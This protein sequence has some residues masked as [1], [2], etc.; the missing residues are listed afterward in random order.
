MTSNVLSNRRRSTTL[1]FKM[2]L[3]SPSMQNFLMKLSS[4]AAEFFVGV[5]KA[6]NEAALPAISALF[7]GLLGGPTCLA[8]GG[9]VGSCAAA[10]IGLG[11]CKPL[12]DIIEK[13]AL[14]AKYLVKNIRIEDLKPLLMLLLSFRSTTY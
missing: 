10:A 14:A 12:A 8:I 2:N 13:L 7:G 1:F 11:Y 6:L 4:Q 9:I 3:L 5:L